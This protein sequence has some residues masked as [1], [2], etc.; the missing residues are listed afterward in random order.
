MDAVDYFDSGFNCAEA[1]LLALSELSQ[2]C[3]CIPRIAT[4]FGGGMRTGN[5]CGAVSGAVMAFGLSYGR[6]SSTQLKKKDQCY[7]LVSEFMNLFEREH[8]TIVCRELLGLD[9]TTEEGR[10]QY[11]M[12]GLH[13]QC[14]TYVATAF[15]IAQTLLGAE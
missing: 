11:K 6:E 14:Q 7:Q 12:L 15:Q 10:E 13:N 3:E 5:V 2:R 4:G 9:V 1:V 8:K